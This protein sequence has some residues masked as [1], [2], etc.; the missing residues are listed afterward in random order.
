MNKRG[1]GAVYLR[2]SIYWLRY[3][4][5]GHLYRESSGSNSEARAAKLLKHRI[6]QMGR[7]GP[8]IGPSEER[9][10]FEDLAALLQTDYA[11]NHR[12]SADK[13]S[14][15]LAHLRQTFANVRAIDTLPTASSPTSPRASRLA[16]AMPPSIANSQ[17]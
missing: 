17:S 11:I 16:P 7:P 6:K 3:W 14:C 5:R 15:R 13:L 4:H 1:F 12:R 10:R 2:G 9:V 8:F